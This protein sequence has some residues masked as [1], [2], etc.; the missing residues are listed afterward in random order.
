ADGLNDIASTLFVIFTVTGVV[1]YAIFVA[2]AFNI[3]R[4]FNLSPEQLSTGRSLT[5]VIG[6][7]VS[8]GFPFSI[9]GGIINGFQRYDL[10][11]VV[12]IGSSAIVALV[13]VAMLAA[14]FSL[15]QLV[16][17]TTSVRILTY[18]AYRLNAYRVFPALSLRPSLFQWS[19]VRELTGF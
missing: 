17:A 2:L 4:V 12:G 6:V 7:Y 13:N 15:V 19:R 10:N 9:F 14:G 11:N 16:A 5:L 8:L 18:F 3:Q 1:A